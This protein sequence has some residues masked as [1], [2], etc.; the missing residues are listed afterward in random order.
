LIRHRFDDTVEARSPAA[1]RR[2][3]SGYDVSEEE[4]EEESVDDVADSV[5]LPA[6]VSPAMALVDSP[7]ACDVDVTGFDVVRASFFAHPEPLNTTAATETALRNWPP[8][9]V[10]VV[11]PG[12]LT[13]WITSTIWPQLRQT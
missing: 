2:A 9:T 4:D 6:A 11:G 5:A 1:R 12:A 8:Q 7:A 10:H 13:P 3:V